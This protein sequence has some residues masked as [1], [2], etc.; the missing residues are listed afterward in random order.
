MANRIPL[1]AG[2]DSVTKLTSADTL[3][4]P[5]PSSSLRRSG[6]QTTVASSAT[7]SFDPATHGDSIRMVLTANVTSWT[8]ASGLSAERVTITWVQSAGANT[9]GG[10]PAN[11][12][13][14]GGVFTLSLGAGA[15]D[16]VEL[17]WSSDAL[18]WEEVT[19][20]LAIS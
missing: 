4:T 16:K 1:V 5:G 11:V 13:Y 9:L 17:E 12:K 6:T 20:S 7:P 19:R 3:A 10:T 8:L 14:T 15:I 2:A 18:Q